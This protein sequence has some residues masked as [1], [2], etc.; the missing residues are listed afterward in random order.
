VK[1]LLGR[2]GLA[3]GF[4]AV[5]LPLGLL[6]GFQYR[7]LLDLEATSA[8]A[9]R[10]YLRNYLEGVSARVETFYRQ[11]AERSLNLSPHVFLDDDPE[12]V[13]RHFR[14]KKPDGAKLLFAVNFVPDRWGG[15]LVF[16]PLTE[17]FG[18]PADVSMARAVSIALAPWK[19]AADKGSPLPSRRTRPTAC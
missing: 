6:L 15:I 1:R 10:S 3:V 8:A 4:V 12:L 14:R 19:T 5:L 2:H 18:E 17:L 16:D 11:Q 9:E 13:A 7:W